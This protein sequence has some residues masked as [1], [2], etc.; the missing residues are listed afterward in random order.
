MKDS[1]A[2]IEAALKKRLYP[3]LRARGFKGSFPHLHRIA[4]DRAHFVST[5]LDKRNHSLRLAIGRGQLREDGLVCEGLPLDKTDVRYMREVRNLHPMDVRSFSL[6]QNFSYGSRVREDG[7][8]DGIADLALEV[9]ERV[10]ESWFAR[11]ETPPDKASAGEPPWLLRSSLGWFARHLPWHRPRVRVAT[12]MGSDERPLRLW[13]SWQHVVPAMTALVELLPHPATIRPWHYHEDQP[14][15]PITYG[16]LQWNQESNRRWTATLKDPRVYMAKTEIWSPARSSTVQARR[17]PDLYAQLGG[18]QVVDEQGFVLAIRLDHLPK[19]A[20]A[21]NK[22]LKAV[23]GVMPASRT[24]IA[25]RTWEE[26]R[27]AGWVRVNNLD[28]ASTIDA[29]E[30]ADANPSRRVGAF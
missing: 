12:V 27:I 26:R 20:A 14:N 17:Y 22:V 8:Y 6:E 23:E 30:W 15:R 11:P 18:G 3:A 25:D 16:L 7:F 9:F 1:S 2:K 10:G 21:A 4:N 24:L 5:F 13:E 29:C 28:D 19:L